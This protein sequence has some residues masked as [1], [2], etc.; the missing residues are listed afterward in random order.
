M[1]KHSF[2][3]LE[4]SQFVGHIND[5]L[6]DDEWISDKLPLTTESF[7]EQ[8]TDGL[9]LAKMINHGVEGTIDERALNYTAGKKP[10]SIFQKMENLQIVVNSAKAIGCSIVNVGP[11]DIRDKNM[12]IVLGLVWQIIRIDLLSSINLKCYPELIKVMEGDESGKAGEPGSPDAGGLVGNESEALLL[13][14]IN[15]HLKKSEVEGIEPVR[16]F[17]SDLADCKALIVLMNQLDPDSVSLNA[18]NNP[19]VL[20][21]AKAVVNAA[22]MM[23]CQQ[24]VTVESLSCANPRLNLAFIANLFRKRSGLGQLSAA[25]R[26]RL[27]L[28]EAEFSDEMD[29]ESKAFAFWLNNVPPTSLTKAGRIGRVLNLYNDLRDGLVLLNTIEAIIPESVNYRRVY[30]APPKLSKFKMIENANYAV[31]LCKKMGLTV[32]GIQ[33]NDIVEGNRKLTLA[34]VWQLMREHIVRTLCD[35]GVRLSDADLLAWANQAAAQ[36]PQNTNQLSISSFKDSGMRNSLFFLYILDCLQPG[37]IQY[38]LVILDDDSHDALRGNARY[39]LTVARKLGATL[40]VMPEDIVEVNAKMILTFIGSLM[41]V[42]KMQKAKQ[43]K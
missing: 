22:K 14:W 41:K 30:F 21:R 38:D 9:V 13:K 10:L 32:V 6:H 23:G 42:E 31:D 1:S 3:S 40:F 43:S 15:Y 5:A 26:Q 25:E 33:G 19:Y 36:C 39:A 34:I 11:L 29:R 27:T 24:F 17:G 12:H 2:D 28:F 18:V 8:L 35:E 37:C 20:E 16:N 4:E 7:M